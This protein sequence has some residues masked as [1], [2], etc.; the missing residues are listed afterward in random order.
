MKT[1]DETRREVAARMRE[2]IETRPD[3]P[4]YLL[5]ATAMSEC[6]PEG[7]MMGPALANLIDPRCKLVRCT[8]IG[9]HPLVCSSCGKMLNPN[10]KWHYFPNCGARR[11]RE[12]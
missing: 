7:M 2:M 11:V 6:L 1:S 4:L 3:L 12:S 9:G 10:I 5:I 8:H